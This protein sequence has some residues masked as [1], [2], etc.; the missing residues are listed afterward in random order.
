MCDRR[1]RNEVRQGQGGHIYDFFMRFSSQKMAEGRTVYLP[2]ARVHNCSYTCHDLA[3][4]GPRLQLGKI[5]QTYV[6]MRN[7]TGT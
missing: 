3:C 7:T 6:K 4:T 2:K 5:L 1:V